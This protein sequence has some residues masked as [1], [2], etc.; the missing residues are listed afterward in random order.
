MKHSTLL[1]AAAMMAAVAAP[2]Q[3]QTFTKKAKKTGA[4]KVM[5]LPMKAQAWRVTKST[6]WPAHINQYYYDGEAWLKVGEYQKA[7]DTRGN[8]TTEYFK[9]YDEDGSLLG[10]TL[11]QNTWNDNNMLLEKVESISEDGGQTYTPSSKRVQ[12]YD[13]VMPSLTISKDKYTWDSDAAA[14]VESYDAFRRTVTRDEW[15]NVTSLV[16]SSPN[17]GVFEPI[18]RITNTVDATSHQISTFKYEELQYDGTW[19]TSYNV[20]NIKW[21][22]TNGQIVDTPD[23]WIENGN[24]VL[25]AT[26]AAYNNENGETSGEATSTFTYDGRGGWSVI[27]LGQQLLFASDGSGSKMFNYKSTTSKTMTDDNGSYEYI[28]GLY[29]DQNED[30][31]FTADEVDTFDKYVVQYDNHGN[32]CLEAQYSLPSDDDTDDSSE[33]KATAKKASGADPDGIVTELSYSTRY[34]FGYDPAHGDA[35]CSELVEQYDTDSQ[36]WTPYMKLD[37]DEFTAGT[38]TG[39]SSASTTA[40]APTTIYNLQGMKLNAPARGVNIIRQEGKT[41]KVMK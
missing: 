19:E 34:T 8:E 40:D 41:L 30:G 10:I 12:T 21:R 13:A 17:N 24:E 31:A 7:Y 37:V 29:Y 4:R 1:L 16:I 28:E 25:S 38:D 36:T 3:A 22:N 2:V 9:E 20:Y 23:T 39:I 15:G 11:T 6:M 14:W 5:A 33:A 26:S 18:I 32:V 35:I 27:E